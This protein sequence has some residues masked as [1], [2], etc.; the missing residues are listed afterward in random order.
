MFAIF[1]V[2]TGEAV[3]NTCVDWNRGDPALFDSLGAAERWAE[4]R[5]FVGQDFVITPV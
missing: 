1:D 4:H 3:K 2:T 5:G